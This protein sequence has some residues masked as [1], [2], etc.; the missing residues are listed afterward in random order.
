MPPSS[1]IDTWAGGFGNDQGWQIGFF[2]DTS[3]DYL[4][5]T[6]GSTM[7][8]KNKRPHC[9]EPQLLAP[10]VGTGGRGSNKHAI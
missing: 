6:T 8:K 9:K 2:S 5:I 3:S 1:T 7:V 10:A 4:V